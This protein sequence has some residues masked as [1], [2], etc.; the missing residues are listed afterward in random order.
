MDRSSA[1]VLFCLPLSIAFSRFGIAMA[2]II[3]M[4]ATTIRSSISVKPFSLR[5]CE[6]SF[7]HPTTSK[8]DAIRMRVPD[9]RRK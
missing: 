9:A 4:M 2:A 3:P 5:I 7:R 8:C 6:T 1:M